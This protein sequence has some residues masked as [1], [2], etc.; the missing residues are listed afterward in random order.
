M[1]KALAIAS[2]A[3]GLGITT[4]TA[5]A[6]QGYVV[7]GS[8]ASPAQAQYLASSGAPP[9]KWVVTGFGI[10]RAAAEAGSANIPTVAEVNGKKCWYVLDVQICD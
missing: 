1:S 7:N 10:T 8:A 9:G 2:L 5:Q 3:V 6:A 4:S